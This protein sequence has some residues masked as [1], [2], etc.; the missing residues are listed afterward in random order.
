M[1][2]PKAHVFFRWRNM[3]RFGVKAMGG[4]V[5]SS[6]VRDRRI[7]LT[8]TLIRLA[9]RVLAFGSAPESWRGSSGVMVMVLKGGVEARRRDM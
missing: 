6:M 9:H 3:G 5:W 2:T 4:H 7:W 8:V 1:A